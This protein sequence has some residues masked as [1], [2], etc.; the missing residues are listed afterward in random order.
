MTF[1]HDHAPYTVENAPD[2]GYHV[3]TRAGQIGTIL[4]HEGRWVVRTGGQELGPFSS[5]DDAVLAV[6]LLHSLGNVE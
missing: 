5:R 1:D 4:D 6:Y 2:G 3:M